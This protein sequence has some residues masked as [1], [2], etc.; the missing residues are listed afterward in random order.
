[1]DENNTHINLLN[2]FIKGSTSPEEEEVL[3]KWFQSESATNDLDSFYL[4]KWNEAS[5]KNLSE[6]IQKKM[7]SQL[8]SRMLVMDKKQHEIPLIKRTHKIQHWI[9]YAAT[10]AVCLGIGIGTYL[11]FRQDKQGSSLHEYVVLADKGQRA[12][13]LLPDG[14]K[15]WLN[16]HSQ[17]SYS[18]DYGVNERHVS[19][20]GE[21]YFEVAKDKKRRFVVNAGEMDVE[22]LGTTFNVK[23]YTDDADVVATLFEGSIKTVVGKSESILL[24]DQSVCF[25][26]KSK[27]L[28]V[29]KMINSSYASMWR[30]NELAFESE[31][32]E[33]IAIL[34]NRLYNVKVAFESDNIK[35]YRFSGVIKNNSLDNVIEIISLTAPIQYSKQEDLIMLSEKK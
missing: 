25:N 26:K 22:A 8:K 5:A 1:M 17:L 30:N 15:V 27:S 19:L 35:N 31:T 3:L 12:S 34:L 29:N 21:A 4:H 13:M 9:S 20:K 24:P 14:T 23:A 6:E 33:N 7:F 10:I 11:Y 2:R 32:L 16:S 28:T 18:M